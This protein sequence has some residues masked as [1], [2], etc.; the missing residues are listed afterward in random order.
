[1]NNFIY[2]FLAY[3]TK[4]KPKQ[5]NLNTKNKKKICIKWKPLK[6]MTKLK[7]VKVQ[8]VPLIKALL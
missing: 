3:I 4:Q 1:M 2:Q 6:K 7:I 8:K 5:Y